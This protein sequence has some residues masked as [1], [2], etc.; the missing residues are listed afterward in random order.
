MYLVKCL[1]A[2]GGLV[3][4]LGM[5]LL[6]EWNKRPHFLFKWPLEVV[7]YLVKCLF[8][9]SMIRPGHVVKFPA[10]IALRKV[11]LTGL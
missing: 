9:S 1:L 7:M 2:R 3:V 8:T 11:D 10:V 5:L 6:A 4:T